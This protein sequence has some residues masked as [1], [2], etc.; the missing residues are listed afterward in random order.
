MTEAYV[1]TSPAQAVINGAL[2][3]SSAGNYGGPNPALSN[4]DIIDELS[5]R[6]S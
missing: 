5:S 4:L 6:T 3:V 1:T 2:L